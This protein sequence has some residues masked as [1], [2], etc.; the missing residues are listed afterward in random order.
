M[1]T[2]VIGLCLLLLFSLFLGACA[3][4]RPG[5]GSQ[6]V[7]VCVAQRGGSAFHRT[8]CVYVR[9]VEEEHKIHFSSREEA[10]A[11]GMKPCEQCIPGGKSSSE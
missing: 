1:R 6:D 11:A 7:Y 8:P 4:Q 9:D 5:P 2:W 3:R 10:E